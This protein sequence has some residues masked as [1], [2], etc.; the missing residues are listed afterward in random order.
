MEE[1]LIVAVSGNPVIYDTTLPTYKHVDLKR[2]AWLKVAQLVGRPEDECRKRWKSLRDQFVR[3]RKKCREASRSGA[4]GNTPPKWR[5]MAIMGFLSPFIEGRPTTSSLP[6][7]LPSS[8]PLRLLP[9]TLPPPTFTQTPLNGPQ[10]QLAR[11]DSAP[12]SPSGSSVCVGP[13]QSQFFSPPPS[14]ARSMSPLPPL[15]LLACSPPPSSPAHSSYTPVPPTPHFQGWEPEMR[16]PQ[17]KQARV[18][19]AF[20]KAI[21]EAIRAP[22]TPPPPAALSSV[23]EDEVFFKSLI[24]MMRRLSTEDKEDIKFKIYGLVFEATRQRSDQ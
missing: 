2:D 20:E 12:P 15:P 11:G 7:R 10:P 5:Y 23:D 14:P 24:P 18:L 8:A 21:L 4:G 16:P 17:E 9:P 13:S 6:R 19:S 3:E 22:S 1:T